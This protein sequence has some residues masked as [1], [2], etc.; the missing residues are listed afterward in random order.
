[1]DNTAGKPQLTATEFVTA[2]LATHPLDASSPRQAYHQ[3]RRAGFSTLASVGIEGRVLRAAKAQVA[4]EKRQ[5]GEWLASH[6]E[7][8]RSVEWGMI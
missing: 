3:A 1:M 8:A 7:G 5:R 2:F 6:Q 4:E